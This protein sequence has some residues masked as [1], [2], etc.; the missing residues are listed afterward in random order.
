[1]TGSHIFGSHENTETQ[2]INLLTQAAKGH[3]SSVHTRTLKQIVLGDGT[4][5]LQGHISSVHT[6]T[7][8]HH[9]TGILSCV[10]LGHI[11][12]VHTRTLKPEYLAS[13]GY[14]SAGSHIF[15]SHE[16]TETSSAVLSRQSS[17]GHISS[18]H[19]RTLKL[20]VGRRALRLRKVTYLRFTREH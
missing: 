17:Q 4:I 7:L 1:M 3:I 16:N 19:T 12:S 6:R 8:K 2:V 15:G 13:L 14:S 9:P 5:Y 11:S 20:T 10:A 18:V